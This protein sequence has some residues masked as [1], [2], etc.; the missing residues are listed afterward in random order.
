MDMAKEMDSLD[1]NEKQILPEESHPPLKSLPIMQLN[2]LTHQGSPDKYPNLL[3]DSIAKPLAPKTPTESIILPPL[4]D[5]FS[6]NIID[7]TMITG[8]ELRPVREKKRKDRKP[9]KKDPAG[10]DCFTIHVMEM[11]GGSTTEIINLG[12]PTKTKK[13]KWSNLTEDSLKEK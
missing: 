5:K 10:K 9:P 7:N 6:S 12:E 4:L 1:H 3:Q 8:V 2:T 11:G 13:L